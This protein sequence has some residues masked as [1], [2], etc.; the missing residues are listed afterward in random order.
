M[1]ALARSNVSFASIDT[2]PKAWHRADAWHEC[3]VAPCGEAGALRW[4][5]WTQ[6]YLGSGKT[7]ADAPDLSDCLAIM[8]RRHRLIVWEPLLTDAPGPHLAQAYCCYLQTVIF[9]HSPYIKSPWIKLF[10]ANG[11]WHRNSSPGH[12]EQWDEIETRIGWND[13]L[14]YR[15]LIFENGSGRVLW[16][17]APGQRRRW[18]MRHWLR[19]LEPQP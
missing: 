17:H 1:T 11:R 16:T 4:H 5:W 7:L 8:P 3:E 15:G 9:Y 10:P 6:A 18:W 12:F 13:R 2:R 19:R 14:E